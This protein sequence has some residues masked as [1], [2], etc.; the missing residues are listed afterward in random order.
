MN[1]LGNLLAQFMAI[2]V[3]M[4]TLAVSSAAVSLWASDGTDATSATP[5][6]NAQMTGSAAR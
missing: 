1:G 4:I 3:I 2:I 6:E 5:T